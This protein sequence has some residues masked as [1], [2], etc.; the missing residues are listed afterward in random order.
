M[1]STS[2]DAPAASGPLSGIRI[3]DMATVLA[4]P[5]S[6]TLC[7]DM[8]AEVIKLELPDGSD[9]LRTLAPVDLFWKVTNRGKKG[10]TLDVR[11]P[12]GKALFLKLIETIDVLVENFRTGTLDKWG[13]DIATLHQ[14][15]PKLI[16]LRLTGFGQT[17]PYAARPGFARIFEAMSGFANLTGDAQSGPQHMNFPLGDVV[18]GLF[19]AFS[20]ATAIVQRAAHPQQRGS[21][22]DL[23]ATEAMMRL[24]D[25]LAAEYEKEGVVRQRAGNRATYTAPSNMYRTGDGAYIT[26]VGSSAVIFRRLCHAMQRPELADDERFC[27]NPARVKHVDVLDGMIA[28]WCLAQDFAAVA[29]ALDEHGVPYSKIYS[30]ADVATDPHYQARQALIRLPDKEHGSL[31]APCIVP[32]ITGFDPAAPRTGPDL[33]EHNAEILSTLG[34]SRDQMDELRGAG[35]I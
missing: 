3:L 8:G 27:S 29:A 32:R 30:I 31:P 33:G 11:K 13:L 25:P 16:V 9:S 2:P 34:L 10:L 21:E 17:G 35:V 7:G 24:L 28:D 26:V 14:A 18:S 6:A 5:F 22:I 23:S 1:T 4:A 12:E 20:I 19:G 15:N